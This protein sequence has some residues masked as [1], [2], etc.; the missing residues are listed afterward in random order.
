MVC[1][2]PGSAARCPIHG[3]APVRKPRLLPGRA[4]Y[5][6]TGPSQ[7]AVSRGQIPDTARTRPRGGTDTDTARTQYGHRTDT[8]P[9]MTRGGSA[10]T[11]D[12]IGDCG[13]PAYKNDYSLSGTC[14]QKG[15]LNIDS[16]WDFG[17]SRCKT[18]TRYR[19]ELHS[20][21][22]GSCDRTELTRREGCTAALGSRQ[23]GTMSHG[24]TRGDMVVSGGSTA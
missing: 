13:A 10:S 8:A 3:L 17:I 4:I 5:L 11:T 2:G 18:I 12:Y 23:P 21:E 1:A 15:R 24:E 19:F 7:A 20:D 22:I 6:P 14:V 9:A 16:S